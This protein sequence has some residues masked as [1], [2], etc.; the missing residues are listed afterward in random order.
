MHH[1]GIER[2]AL[3]KK[4]IPFLRA[5]PLLADL[6]ET[7]ISQLA[8][9]AEFERRQ[10]GDVLVE[11]GEPSDWF[12]VV[13]EGQIRLVN[14]QEEKVWV[15]RY[16]FEGDLGGEISLLTN[17]PQ[18]L[19]EEVVV[20][21]LL[22]VFDRS[23]FEW[24]IITAPDVSKKLRER[25]ALIERQ[26]VAA[27]AGQR[28]SEAIVTEHKRHL[29]AFLA[30]LPGPMLLILLG[31]GVGFLLFNILDLTSSLLIS[32]CF[33]SL[34]L[35]AILYLYLDWRNDDFIVTSERAIHIE[36]ILLHGETRDEAPLTSIQDIS[37]IVPNLF[38]KIFDY[39]D[40]HIQTAG[41][42]TI[43]FDGI[44][45]ADGLRDELFRQRL[46]A[47]ERVE[48]ADVR[49]L[50]SNIKHVVSGDMPHET[51]AFEPSEGYT[52]SS[53]FKLPR[54]IDFFIPRTTEIKGD[55][56][57]WR[58]NYFVFLR[59]VTGPLVTMVAFVY[60]TLA[61]LFG[62]FPFRDP[63]LIWMGMLL[64]GWPFIL[65]WYAYRYDIWRKD[66]YQLTKTSIIDYKGSAFNLHGEQRRVG[67]FDVI[68]N[69]TYDTPNFV[70]KLLNVGHVIIE[71]AGT[72][73]TF[74]FHWVYNPS[75]VQQEIFKRWLAYKD[76]QI[77]QDR[78]YEEQRIAS[79][80][81]TYH[82]MLASG[83]IDAPQKSK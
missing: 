42:G 34:G 72:E 65:V 68:Q 19:T 47:Q 12:Y 31:V 27:F 29:V 14:Q 82:D 24:L 70:A 2:D 66:E 80:L 20:D 46:K 52:P 8:Q 37:V 41:A 32:G 15:E 54:F 28:Y 62:F 9:R 11:Q 71:T 5:N 30:S 17:D 1:N 51:G 75:A 53:G 40:L 64:L 36:R 77:E 45:G 33:F 7:Q 35:L 57:I 3:T 13:L 56:I 44:K 76:S 63:T 18:P 59:L 69:L 61:A 6:T 60:L 67:P 55:I 39:S 49:S 21:A 38:A 22:A 50:R 26:A 4:L 78:A 43:I 23:A 83:E 16:L 73:R 81:G 10:V 79:W 74:T 25:A 48:V 58:K